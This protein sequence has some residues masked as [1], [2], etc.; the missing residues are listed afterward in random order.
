[1]E[2]QRDITLKQKSFVIKID[3]KTVK[4]TLTA[5]KSWL[6]K[7]Y[8]D[9]TRLSILEYRELENGYLFVKLNGEVRIKVGNNKMILDNMEQITFKIYSY[10][11]YMTKIVMIKTIK[12]ENED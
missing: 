4:E 11:H 3:N 7:Q 2:K 9:N 10:N 6:H 5:L 1:M 12:M 8:P